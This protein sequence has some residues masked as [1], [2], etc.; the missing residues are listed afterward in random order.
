MEKQGIISDSRTPDTERR[1]AK[2]TA[3]VVAPQQRVHELDND[4]TKR[5]MD[6][7]ATKLPARKRD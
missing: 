5:L 1:L 3:A 7:A 2:K 6:K 4:I